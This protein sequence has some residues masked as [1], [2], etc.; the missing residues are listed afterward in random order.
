MV[1]KC[2]VFSDTFLSIKKS[3][4]IKIEASCKEILIAHFLTMTV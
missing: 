3:L 1:Y 4:E 2:N